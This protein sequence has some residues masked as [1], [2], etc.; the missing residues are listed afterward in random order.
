MSAPISVPSGASSVG[1][2]T[3]TIGSGGTSTLSSIPNHVTSSPGC[4]FSPSNL[5][6]STLRKFSTSENTGVPLQTSWTFWLDKTNKNSTAAEY[7]ANLRKIYTVGTV[8]GFWSVYNNIPDV[9]ELK[10]RHYYHLM[11][12]E[13]EPLWED[14]T[15]SQGGV[16]RIKCQK[17]DSSRV[18]KELL[19]AS[20]G[21][22]FTDS[23]APGDDVVGLSF[24]PREREDIIQIWNIDSGSVEADHVLEKVHALVPDVRFIAE[25]YKPHQTHS[26]FEGRKF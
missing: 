19:L 10:F 18:W 7:K 12:N 1:T 4:A 14:P 8:Q 2:S 11:R 5:S 24:S 3:S 26:A 23:V 21:E 9:N 25:F 17:K 16:W 15:L 6:A 20:I 22:Q 13:R